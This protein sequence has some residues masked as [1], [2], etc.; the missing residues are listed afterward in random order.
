[1]VIYFQE[2]NTFDAGKSVLANSNILSTNTIVK[3]INA[4]TLTSDTGNLNTV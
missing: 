1:M 4:K 2:T 3:L